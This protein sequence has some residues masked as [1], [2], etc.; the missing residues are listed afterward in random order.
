M[1]PLNT[2]DTR[3]F[4]A[5][6]SKNNDKLPGQ[7]AEPSRIRTR[8]EDSD[9]DKS[10][11]SLASSEMIKKEEVTSTS[12]DSAL[13]SALESRWSAAL[14]S[15]KGA[16]EGDVK[17]TNVLL[18]FVIDYPAKF[19][20]LWGWEDEVSMNLRQVLEARRIERDLQNAPK[21]VFKD[22]DPIVR[23]IERS[24]AKNF[25]GY[26]DY[27]SSANDEKISSDNQSSVVPGD[28][29][30]NPASGIHEDEGGLLTS[31][32]SPTGL[33]GD[34]I[35]RD[36]S[37]DRDDLLVDSPTLG[38][39]QDSPSYGKGGQDIRRGSTNPDGNTGGSVS[40]KGIVILP[41][42]N[43]TLPR[44][45][46]KKSSHFKGAGRKAGTSASNIISPANLTGTS[47]SI[48]PTA[49]L[50]QTSPA[51][52]APVLQ[53]LP[54]SSAVL[55]YGPSSPS[56][57]TAVSQSIHGSP[58]ERT[59]PSSPPTMPGVPLESSPSPRPVPAESSQ[60]A[61]L[62]AKD[63]TA[64]GPS[65]HYSVPGEGMRAASQAGQATQPSY[66]KQKV[67]LSTSGFRTF[68]TRLT[69]LLAQRDS[70]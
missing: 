52:V 16:K 18:D 61:P 21:P 20:E 53:S 7:S 44:P 62:A 31:K 46:K 26:E 56:S 68:P 28:H 22:D 9:A 12:N 36:H 65:S 49:S 50:T 58:I 54:E 3:M 11:P 64:G 63:T 8:V 57:S 6:F 14:K 5:I 55:S 41:N 59:A 1:P 51:L 17:D 60:P 33:T 27:D 43:S 32:A 13:D 10:T 35:P 47:V 39:I 66:A 40:D 48:S 4:D 2:E 24:I 34:P 15:R 70:R 67:S 25:Y 38:S 23:A 30:S 42:S 37:P 19:P 29:S 69:C 45:S